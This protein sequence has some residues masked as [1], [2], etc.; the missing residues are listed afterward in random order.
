MNPEYGGKDYYAILG[1]NSSASSEDIKKAFLK[2]CKETHPDANQDSDSSNSFIDVNNA[3]ETLKDARK[4]AEYNRHVGIA[5]YGAGSSSNR[6]SG[7]YGARGTAAS[8]SDFRYQ[9]RYGSSSDDRFHTAYT[10]SDGVKIKQ[11]RMKEHIKT[12]EDLRAERYFEAKAHSHQADYFAQQQQR[13]SGGTTGGTAGSSGHGGGGGGSGG[14]G[15][16]SGGTVGRAARRTGSAGMTTVLLLGTIAFSVGMV[17][18]RK[19]RG[20]SRR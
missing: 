9:P 13:H 16:G 10:T 1:V 12:A 5:G 7:N 17:K 15:T 2:K 20:G 11:R 6:R 4:R 8:R 3:F 19:S 18:L 14:G